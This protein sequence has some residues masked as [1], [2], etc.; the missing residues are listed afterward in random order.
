MKILIVLFIVL[1]LTSCIKEIDGPIHVDASI[2][3]KI[4]IQMV[5][6]DN[7]KYYK[8]VYYNLET[9][10]IVK[11][12]NS[13]DWFIAF[14][15]DINSSNQKIIMNPA[16]N[17]ACNG[18]TLKDTNFNEVKSEKIFD[19][20][21]LVYSNYYDDFANLFSDNF[22]GI[23]SKNYV[24]YLHFGDL[25]Y[26]KFQI[27]NYSATSV[28]FRYSKLNNTNYFE[29]TVPIV[30]T[31]NF[32]YFSFVTNSV[33]DIEPIDKNSWD[34]EFTRFTTYITDFGQPQMYG[35]NGVLFN[36]AKTIT[37][38]FID[39]NKIENIDILKTQNLVYTKDLKGIGY[40]W[41]IYSAAGPDG[42][43]TIAP[44]VYILKSDINTYVIQFTDYSKLINNV[45][46]RGYPTFLQNKL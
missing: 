28:T 25:G 21:P 9:K 16:Y 43:Y 40:S 6:S 14:N 45:S 39:N 8:K 2:Y 3:D 42:F 29:A 35:V 38:S 1:N 10:S 7:E 20:N 12:S 19:T 24:Y 32:T 13:K 5:D 46:V 36:P 33:A 22:N 26:Y 41:K 11:S 34:I 27:I 37:S 31:Q 18:F 17:A 4:E 23:T 30:S 15:S 44:R